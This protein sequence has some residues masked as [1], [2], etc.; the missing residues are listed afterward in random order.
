MQRREFVTALAATLLIA[1]M[2]RADAM[3]DS[4]ERQ[5]R[6]QGFTKM[7]VTRTWLGR[8]RIVATSKTQTREIIIN[9]RTGEILRDYWQP[10]ATSGQVSASDEILDSRPNSTGGE[11]EGVSDA[12]SGS[13]DGGSS[14]DGG[15]DSGGDSGSSG[16]DHGGDGSGSGGDGGGD[17]GDGGDG[18]SD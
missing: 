13:S 1:P 16:G 17:G 15:G 11:A 5:L 14:S 2:A 10:L 4:V 7:H 3:T 8:T 12:S 18:G 6:A 9:P